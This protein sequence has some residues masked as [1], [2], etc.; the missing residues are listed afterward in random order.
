MNKI[1]DLDEAKLIRKGLFCF[2][3]LLAF[4][5]LAIFYP[6]VY[7]FLPVDETELCVCSFY[8][9][10]ADK[11]KGTFLV[12]NRPEQYNTL[13]LINNTSFY[14]LNWIVLALL[15]WMVYKIRK[16][17]DET[18]IKKETVTIVAIWLFASFS[19]FTAFF[20]TQYNDCYRGNPISRIISNTY[21][22]TYLII[23]LRD[24]SVLAIMI[25]FQFK[26]SRQTNLCRASNLKLKFNSLLFY[27]LVPDSIEP[28]DSISDKTE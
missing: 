26:V 27:P 19:Q 18:L 11:G 14:I 28:S 5:V 4:G 16:M 9:I 13:Q 24:I 15:I 10:L 7:A 23:I 21:V 1:R 12:L 8:K 22:I 6:Y 20:V 3:P 2:F 25:Y 17:D